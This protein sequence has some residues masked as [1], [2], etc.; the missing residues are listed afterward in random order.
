[1][2]RTVVQDA[3]ADRLRGLH[4]R[5]GCFP[6]NLWP[7]PSGLPAGDVTALAAVLA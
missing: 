7:T 2:L 4:W 3:A 1:L 6:R 5:H